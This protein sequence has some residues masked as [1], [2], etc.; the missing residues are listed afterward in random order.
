VEL[1]WEDWT[2]LSYPLVGDPHN[3]IGF[4]VQRASKGGGAK[5]FATIATLRPYDYNRLCDGTATPPVTTNCT[6]PG[7]PA[8]SIRYSDAKAGANSTYRYRVVS[9]NAAG[10]STSNELAVTTVGR[11][12]AAPTALSAA[13]LS[14]T[15]ILL[16]WTDNATN[17]TGFRITR[18]NGGTT[19]ISIGAHGGTGVMTYTDTPIQVGQTY[20]YTVIAVNV[21]GGVTYPSTSASVTITASILAPT[22]LTA[23]LLT[24]PL[25]VL[26]NWTDNANNEAAYTVA[27]TCTGPTCVAFTTVTLAANTVTYTNNTGLAV[28]NTYVYT[29]TATN[30]AVTSTSATVS[31]TVAAPNAPSGLAATA[32]PAGGNRDAVTLTWSDNS[33]TETSSTIQ[34]C[35]GT[36]AVCTPTAAGWANV[37]T[38]VPANAIT[39]TQTGVN[40]ATTYS[41]RIRA[42]NALGNS[43][44]SNTATVLTP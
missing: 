36:A 39:Y 21:V 30:G 28:G 25:R 9:Y 42:V 5:A 1:V 6:V 37:T 43:A 29:V 19:N 33:N 27:R 31:V 24:A 17:E 41:Y 13:V 40:R 34:R 14:A 20:T 2:P 7:T 23:T 3:E 35:T 16:T 44:W 32:V 26:L 8:D 38:T 10:A 22:N 11:T 18:V 15:Q 12:P 4:Q